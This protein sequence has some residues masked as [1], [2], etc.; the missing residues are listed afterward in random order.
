MALLRGE[1]ERAAQEGRANNS[2]SMRWLHRSGGIVGTADR[3]IMARRGTIDAKKSAAARLIMVRC[4]VHRR[5]LSDSY[6]A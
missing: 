5:D 2:F 3:L 6:D 4:M 1:C